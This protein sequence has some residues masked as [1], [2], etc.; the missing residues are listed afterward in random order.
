MGNRMS[1]FSRASIRCIAA[2]GLVCVWAGASQ[3]VGL[4]CDGSG[5][6]STLG[7]LSSGANIRGAGVCFYNWQVETNT[8]GLDLSLVDVSLADSAA[9]LFEGGGVFS[10]DGSNAV[11]LTFSFDVAL[12]P[13]ME[14][15]GASLDITET[16]FS[17]SS[18]F[19]YVDEFLYPAGGP[20]LANWVIVDPFFGLGGEPDSASFDPT[21]A[22]SVRTQVFVTSEGPGVS[23]LRFEQAFATRG[24]PPS[25]LIPNP[26][27]VA[28]L[29]FGSN[30]AVIAW[31]LRRRRRHY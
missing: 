18:G 15:L 6:P 12:E 17:A 2:L 13:G 28:A 25:S 14:I 30:L 1:G 20:A 8:S 24:S 27:P 11:S 7:G 3:A 16:L 31:V 9:L 5:G 4:A 19:L 10:V 23:L 22:L 29:I 26:E 21:S